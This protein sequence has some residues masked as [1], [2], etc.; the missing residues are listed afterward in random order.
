MTFETRLKV[1][2]SALKTADFVLIGAG[3]SFSAA[4]GLTYSGLRF[5]D[6]FQRHLS[7]NMA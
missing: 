3:V 5:T 2:K 1:V 4:A 6:N 7:E